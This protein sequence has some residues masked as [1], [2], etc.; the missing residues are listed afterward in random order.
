MTQGTG[1]LGD[2]SLSGI[3]RLRQDC[4]M[5]ESALKLTSLCSNEIDNQIP[6]E[7]TSC[8]SRFENRKSKRRPGF[9]ERPKSNMKNSFAVIRSR[10]FQIWCTIVVLVVVTST[11]SAL[12]NCPYGCNCNDETLVVVCEASRLDVLPI[13]LNP[14]IQRLVIRNNKIKTIDSSIQ[15]YAELHFLDLS[16]N[17]LVNIPTKSFDSQKKLQELHLNHNKI[18]S[19]SNWTFQGL[20]SLTVLNLR[21]NFLEELNNG[22]FSTL[23]RLEE[24]NLGQNRISRLDPNAFNGLLSLRILYLDDNQLNSVPTPS[25]GLLGSLAELHVGLNAFTYL[26][27]DAFAGLNRL[28]VL[29]L[30]GAGLS[31]IS[32]SAFRGLPGL[33]SLDL[34]GNKLKTI[35]TLQ[36]SELTRLEDLAIGQND[37]TI[38]ETNTFQGLTNLRRLD[39]TGASLLEKIEKGAFNENMNLDS[40]TL[41]SNK[42]LYIIEEGALVGLPNL[43]HLILKENAFETL[44]ESMLSWKELRRLE[45]TDNPLYCNCQLLWL[46]DLL[47]QRNFTQAQCAGPEHLK[48]KLL[49]TLTSDDLGCAM[50]DT[51]QQTIICI[52][53]V[54]TVAVLATLVL[55]SYRYRKRVQDK[56]KDYKW[57]KRAI[58]RKEHEYQKTFSEDDYMRGIH[59]PHFPNAQQPHTPGL[60]PIPVTEL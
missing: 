54:V 31:N 51:R 47:N 38:L 56:L 37:F 6:E 55:V 20:S 42:R 48:E 29:D 50:H 4:N 58:S 46:Q 27:D 34:S 2:A 26:P 13:A 1:W 52:S 33:R 12:A 57:N 30:N 36:L 44:T 5:R 40:L 8:A 49:R 45:L 35:P 32:E 28:T 43:R 19:V 11:A 16:Y 10:T 24:L 60:R 25:F 53:V 59:P 15:F 21:G 9:P 7:K 17:H 22:V 39:I 18:S 14:S 3:C 23:P 41:A